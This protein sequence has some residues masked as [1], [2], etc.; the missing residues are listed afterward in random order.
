[1]SIA[2]TNN[3][4]AVFL[5]NVAQGVRFEHI[6]YFMEQVGKVIF[7]RIVSNGNFAYVYYTCFSDAIRA[8]EQLD[9]SQFFGRRLFVQIHKDNNLIIHPFPRRN[10]KKQRVNPP[11]SP[12]SN[13]PGPPEPAQ[14]Q[15]SRFERNNSGDDEENDE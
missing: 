8:V 7:V 1:M 2:Q 6:K 12:I 9:Q 14:L 3:N 4:Y 5:T 15:S 13:E 10:D 11:P